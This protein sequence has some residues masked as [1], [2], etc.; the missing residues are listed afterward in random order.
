MGL[1]EGTLEDFAEAQETF[2]N[3]DILEACRKINRPVIECNNVGKSV[4]T[5]LLGDPLDG[6]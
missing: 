2:K 6:R 1:K 3:V 4:V 5:E